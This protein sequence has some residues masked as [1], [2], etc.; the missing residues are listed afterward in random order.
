MVTNHLKYASDYFN[1]SPGIRRALEYLQHADLDALAQGRH[2]VDGDRV[3][4]LVSEYDT[5]SPAETFWEAHRRHIDVQ[6]VHEGV[7]RIGYGD[8]ATFELEP[9]DETRDLTVA[10]GHSDRFIELGAG[11]FAILFPHDVH[12]PGLTGPAV[13]RVRKAVVKVRV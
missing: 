12:M 6:Y 5:R 4:V 1:L 8:L 7:E 2:D 10:H 13:R 11:E 9:Y 3:F